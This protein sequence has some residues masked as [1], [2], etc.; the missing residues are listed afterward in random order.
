VSTTHSFAEERPPIYST[1]AD[2]PDMAEL[3]EMFID[4]LPQ[5]MAAAD[6]LAGRSDWESLGRLAHQLKGAAGSYGFPELTDSAATLERACR[7][8]RD[9]AAI[10]ESLAALADTCSR[11]RFREQ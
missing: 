7:I 10:R 1:L 8:D 5:R 11:V 2:D 9:E 3:V 6:E 4:E